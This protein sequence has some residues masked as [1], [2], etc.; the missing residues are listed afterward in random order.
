MKTFK[1]QTVSSLKT[2][3]NSSANL[4]KVTTNNSDAFALSTIELILYW[5]LKLT[6]IIQI[7]KLQW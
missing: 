4:K 3:W 5:E 7:P 6:E 1:Y 2:K